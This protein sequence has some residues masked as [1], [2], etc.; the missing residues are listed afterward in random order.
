MATREYILMNF[1]FSENFNFPKNVLFL[2]RILENFPFWKD[3]NS[4]KW[5]QNSG[6]QNPFQYHSAC[7]MFILTVWLVSKANVFSNIEISDLKTIKKF[8]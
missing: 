2:N 7:I 4:Q 6:L 1:K 5:N 3:N 8:T